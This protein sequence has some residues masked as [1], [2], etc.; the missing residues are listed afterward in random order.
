VAPAVSAPTLRLRLLARLAAH[1]AHRVLESATEREVANDSQQAVGRGIKVL[2]MH[3]ASS[4]AGAPDAD[5]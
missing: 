5:P 3:A 4:G 2:M 1:D